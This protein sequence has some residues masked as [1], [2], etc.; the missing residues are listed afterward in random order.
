MEQSAAHD[1]D[2]R[3]DVLKELGNIGVGNALTAI[4]AM[5]DASV[6]MSVPRAGIVPIQEIPHIMGGPEKPVSAV[7]SGVTGEVPGHV[8]FVLPLE[9]ALATIDVLLR[10]PE[11]TTRVIDEQG[12]SVIDEVGNI[13]TSAFLT[14]LTDMSGLQMMPTPPETVV[15]MAAAVLTGV[16]LGMGPPE[17]G[18][19]LVSTRVEENKGVVEGSFFYIPQP[20]SLGKLLKA[21]GVE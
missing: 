6:R 20:G 18:V 14:A 10:R 2:M 13:M 12:A 15:D 11:G 19:L 8:A 9:S 3:F 17:E 16:L 21:L 1:Y 7:H 5:I 4:S